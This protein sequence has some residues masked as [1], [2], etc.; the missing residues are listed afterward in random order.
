MMKSIKSAPLILTVILFLIAQ[1]A[2]AQQTNVGNDENNP[3]E[4]QERGTNVISKNVYNS[5]TFNGYTISEINATEGNEQAVQQQLWGIPTSIE[6]QGARSRLFHFG[7]NKAAFN[8][9]FNHA[10]NILIK[11]SKWQLIVQEQTIR[12]GD[13]FL[14]LQQKFTE[15]LKIRYVPMIG[16]EYL[17]FFD[18]AENAYDGVGIYFNPETHKIQEIVYFTNP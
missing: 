13:T 7:N 9:E 2:I 15:D 3:I 10:T 1:T 11:D 8:T 5:I 4:T 17:V 6:E 14:S 16:P 12:V 18:H